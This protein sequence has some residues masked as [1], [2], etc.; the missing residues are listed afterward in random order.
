[1]GAGD[2]LYIRGDTYAEG[3]D[4]GRQTIPVGTSW[5]NAPLISAYPNEIVQINNIGLYVSYIQYIIFDGLIV[6][7]GR[8]LNEDIYIT[9]G[10][11]HIQIKKYEIRNSRGQGVLIARQSSV[12]NKFP[13]CRIYDNGSSDQDHG[14]YLSGTSDLIDMCNIYNNSGYGVHN[15]NSYPGDRSS[16]NIIRNSGLWN[17]G[18]QSATAAGILLSSGDGNLAY[19]NIIRSNPYGIQIGFRSSN[20][21]AAYNNTIYANTYYGIQLLILLC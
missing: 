15:Y 3:I 18:T 19:N 12:F 10:A 16:N 13:N 2:T 7:N 1:M 17:N 21:S 8:T 5:S 9:N 4:S 6:D 11:N 20:M 14:L